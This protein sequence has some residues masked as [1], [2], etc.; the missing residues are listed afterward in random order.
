MFVYTIQLVVNLV[1]TGYQTGCIVYTNIQ[2]VVKPGWIF[3]YTKQPD[4]KPVVLRG[5]TIG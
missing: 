5:L 4:V 1:V 3:V 2:P